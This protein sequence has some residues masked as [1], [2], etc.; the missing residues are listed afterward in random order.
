MVE[1]HEQ[2]IPVR[3]FLLLPRFQPFGTRGALRA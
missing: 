3:G 2:R 1:L